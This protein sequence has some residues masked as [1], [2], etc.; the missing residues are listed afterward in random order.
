MSCGLARLFPNK[1]ITL[2]QAEE[3]IKSIELFVFVE[4][5]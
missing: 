4:P 3:N 5:R 2:F 1:L